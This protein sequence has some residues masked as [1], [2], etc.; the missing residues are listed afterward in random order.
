MELFV[1]KIKIKKNIDIIIKEYDSETSMLS[2]RKKLREKIDIDIQKY[3]ESA[4][5]KESKVKTEK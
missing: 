3:K 2:R 1:I 5:S 4:M